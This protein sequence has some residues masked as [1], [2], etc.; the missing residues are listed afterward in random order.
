[1]GINRKHDS[2]EKTKINYRIPALLYWIFETEAKYK[3]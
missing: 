1:M 2:E 3:L